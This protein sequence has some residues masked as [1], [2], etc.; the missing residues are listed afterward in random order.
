[1]PYKYVHVYG[2]N[3]FPIIPMELGVRVVNSNYGCGGD[4]IFVKVTFNLLEEDKMW[5]MYRGV[6]YIFTL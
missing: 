1:M 6:G 2:G 4:D 3:I 5:D